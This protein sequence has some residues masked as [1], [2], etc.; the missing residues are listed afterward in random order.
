MKIGRCLAGLL[1]AMP[2]VAGAGE[3]PAKPASQE[4]KP[5]AAR[6]A[7]AQ[8]ATATPA[9]DP[10]SPLQTS[11]QRS[12]YAIGLSMGKSM[13]QQ[14]VELDWATFERGV[15]D[16]LAG[17]QA[18]LSEEQVMETMRSLQ[19]EMMN[20]QMAKRQAQGEANKKTGEELR[21]ANQAKQGV[22]VLPSGLQYEVLQAGA[23]PRPQAGDRVKVHYRGTLPDGT[24]FDSSY[25]RGEP[26]VF[27]VGAVIPGWTEILQLM[28]VGSKWKVVIPPELAYGERGAGPRIGPHSTLVFEIELL[29]IEPAAAPEEDEEAESEAEPEAKA[30]P[31]AAADEA[32][33]DP[34]ER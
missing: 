5:A 12:S 16:G 26:A 2:L 29:G 24:E 11:Q 15:R 28:P 1:L 10:A 27:P 20:K 34:D 18:L 21:R 9:V 23:G 14:E 31:Q 30:K 6:P 7:T 13:R 4:A 17:A 19:Q 33:T 8:P 3:E 22:T 25:G 32:A